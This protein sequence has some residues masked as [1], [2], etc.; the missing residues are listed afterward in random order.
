MVFTV[1]E[2]SGSTFHMSLSAE[3]EDIKDAIE[4]F[5]VRVCKT[6]YFELESGLVNCIIR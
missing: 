5:G 4:N 6:K 1:G 2:Y 3:K